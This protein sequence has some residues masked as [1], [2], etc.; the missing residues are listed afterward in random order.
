VTFAFIPIFITC[1][2]AIGIILMA[3]ISQEMHGLIAANKPISL[4]QLAPYALC[5]IATIGLLIKAS[6]M[7]SSMANGFATGSANHFGR[8][9]A[10]TGAMLFGRKG[11]ERAVSGA[12]TVKA[13]PI[14]S[15]AKPTN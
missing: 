12:A 3:K 6:F 4:T 15:V 13:N 1:A 5:S 7:A 11:K 9:G 10:A 8:I 2:L 14:S